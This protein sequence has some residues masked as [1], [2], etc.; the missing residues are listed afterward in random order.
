M[1]AQRAE[2]ASMSTNRFRYVPIKEYPDYSIS[3]NGRI[4]NASTKTVLK[5]TENSDGYLTNCINGDTL[6]VHRLVGIQFLKT[7][8]GK[9]EIDHLNHDLSDNRLLNLR[10]SNRSDNN[11]NKVQSLNE[12]NNIQTTEYGT[13]RTRNKSGERKTFKTL[14]DAKLLETVKISVRSFTN[15]LSYLFI[16]LR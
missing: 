3:K 9:T 14:Q 11:K 2:H 10:W 16:T 12:M 1:Q 13:Y 8:A 5:H 15:S 7:I 4:R 6:Y